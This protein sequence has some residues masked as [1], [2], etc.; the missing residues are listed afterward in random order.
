[1]ARKTVTLV[2]PD[3]INVLCKM[4][5]SFSFN[6]FNDSYQREIKFATF[7]DDVGKPLSQ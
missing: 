7:I 3:W 4:N 2:W 1:M 5:I 6:N